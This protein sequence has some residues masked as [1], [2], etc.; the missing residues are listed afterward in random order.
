MLLLAVGWDDVTDRRG[1]TDPESIG[2][3]PNRGRVEGGF[4]SKGMSW[5]GDGKC[6]G[7]RAFLNWKGGLSACRARPR[8][9][10][11]FPD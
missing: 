6:K 5:C 1:I 10:Y 4:D 3:S 9:T 2:S 7:L 11:C 8:Y